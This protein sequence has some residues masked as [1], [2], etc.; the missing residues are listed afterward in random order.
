MTFDA[1]E[2]QKTSATRA[3]AVDWDGPLW[4]SYGWQHSLVVKGSREVVTKQSLL[5]GIPGATGSSL[6]NCTTPT[7]PHKSSGRNLTL[8]KDC[9][10]GLALRGTACKFTSLASSTTATS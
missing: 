4:D 6:I 10:L 1:N 3:D 9:Q 8:R 2:P 5:I 7:A